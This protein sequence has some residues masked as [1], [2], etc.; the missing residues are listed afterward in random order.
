MIIDLRSIPDNSFLSCDLCIIGGGAAG[1]TMALE[2]AETGIEVILLESGGLEF[3]DETQALYQGEDIGLPYFDI[4]YARL[5]YFGGTTNHWGG[6]CRP[7]EPID[8]ENRD[9]VA[10][11]GWPISYEQFAAYL[12]RAG[13]LV[14]IENNTYDATYWLKHEAEITG[15]N[16]EHYEQAL[17]HFDKDFTLG[18]FHFSPPTKFGE[19]YRSSLNKSGNIKVLL[20]ANV[21][22]IDTLSNPNLVDQL[23]VKTLNGKHSSIKAD[24]VVLATGGIENA[25]LLLASNQT[26][27]QGLGNT[28]DLVGRYFADHIELD[29][30]YVLSTQDPEALR[31][32][33]EYQDS[34]RFSLDISP[35]TQRS[36][37]MMNIGLT[38]TEVPNKARTA[39]G[40]GA[41]RRLKKSIDGGRWPDNFFSDVGSAI[42]DIDD[43]ISYM[44]SKT[45]IGTDGLFLIKSRVEP[46]PNPKSRIT[47][48]EDKD[49]LGMPRVKLDWQLTELDY[50]SV[51]EMQSMFGKF[52]GTARLGRINIELDKKFEN[53]P[54]VTDGGYHHM[55]TTRMANSSSS[56]VVD[57]NCKVFGIE[58][59]YIAGSS[60]FPTY[61]K[62]NPTINLIA[63]T[64]RLADHLKVKMETRT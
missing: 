47:L 30:G 2:F 64:L 29:S 13:N 39:D 19:A 53:W 40:V 35:G 57:K 8:F 23:S 45:K 32:L 14:Q 3:E 37:K 24:Q 36:K 12:P 25:R 52:L 4:E 50:N 20:N 61:G 27:A 41:A 58:N 56:G 54:S 6:W 34:V 15:R 62:A 28:H 43:V 51:Y 16:H 42:M 1:I 26:H 18:M 63:L 49:A 59:L 22:S 21:T 44:G 46:Q 33:A 55:G 60:V 38:L 9:W 10:H 48:S 5:R 31:L 7:L 11:S 17:S